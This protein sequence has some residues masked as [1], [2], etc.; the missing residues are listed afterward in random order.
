MKKRQK[1]E[2]FDFIIV[3]SW[4]SV[5]DKLPS[6]EDTDDEYLVTDGEIVD[7][8]I[9]WNKVGTKKKWD[10]YTPQIIP[11]AVTHWILVPKPPQ[12]QN[13]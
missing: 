3:P 10:F 13:L 4:I 2:S 12:L 7:L 1:K 8:A 6:K 11:G 5:K 9:W